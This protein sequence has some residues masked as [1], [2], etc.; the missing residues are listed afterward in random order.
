MSR[1]CLCT[2]SLRQILAAAVG[3][4]AMVLVGC[5][6]QSSSPGRSSTAG[7]NTNSNAV[8]ASDSSKASDPA[9]ATVAM[10]FPTGN[11][12]T[13]DLL[14]EEIG[15]CEA[16]VGQPYTY[17]LRVTNLRSTPLKGVVLE[18]RIPETF[19]MASPDAAATPA[20]APADSSAAAPAKSDTKSDTKSMAR[21][22]VG[23]LAP[24]EAKTVQMTGTPTQQGTLDTCLSARFNP[25][26]LCS[27]VNVVAPA[28][29]I[30]AEGPS[31]A[32]VCADLVYHYRVTNT[33]TGT[34]HNVV[35]Q[36]NL[37]DGLQTTD[38]KNSISANLGD[39][40]AGQ[41]KDVTAHLKAG[42]PGKFSTQAAVASDDAGRAQAEAV[43]TT[44]MAPRLAVTVAGPKEDYLGQPLTY[45]V[46]VKNNGDAPA[47]NTKVRL[48]ATPGS[49]EFV[50][51]QNADGSKL[52]QEFS[53]GGQSL[54]TLAPGES[55]T[56]SITFRSLQQGQ[57]SLSATAEAQCAQPVTT[58]VNTQVMTI[59]ASALIVT[60]D[61]DP[62]RVGT[63]V[64]YHITV[65]NKGSAADHNVNVTAALPASEQFVKGN[66]ST[67]VTADGQTITLGTIPELA[68]K[69]SLSWDVEAKAI[70]ADEAQLKVSMTSESTQTAA[71][72]IEPT[73]LYGDEANTQQK[74]NE[75]AV[76]TPVNPPTPAPT[77][78]PAP[79]IN[80]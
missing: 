42:Q 76:P 21:I 31:Q 2:G 77:P 20:A 6:E 44:L 8:L 7:M 43:A 14:V 35:L 48:G 56:V 41:N 15:A 66:G 65:Q 17:Q 40:T 58:P 67:N 39:I 22:D 69:Q 30:T 57:L 26:M 47:A 64:I 63:D 59:T 46:T 10:A 12:A 36:E 61:P 74:T 53:G 24:N 52:S 71:V 23:D 75:A 11:R 4:F 38:G 80:K 3:S 37:P 45:Q 70:K 51:A 49:V 55:H 9:Q 19:Q 25:P 78:A 13:S 27:M 60:H 29:R 62:V 16:R 1:S 18:Q 28:L 34:A 73:K 50:S 5:S 33:G 79:D 72:K 68:P 32:D 54:G